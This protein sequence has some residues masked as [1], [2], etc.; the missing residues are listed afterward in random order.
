MPARTVGTQKC[1][2]G[3]DYGTWRGRPLTEVEHQ[4][5]GPRVSARPGRH[6]R[7]RARSRPLPRPPFSRGLARGTDRPPKLP[8]ICEAADRREAVAAVSFG[9]AT[10]SLTRY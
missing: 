5:A 8:H 1:R 4:V 10:G 7:L 3:G 2:D 9:S 6:R